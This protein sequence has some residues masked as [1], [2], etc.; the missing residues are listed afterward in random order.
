MFVEATAATKDWRAV[1]EIW[2]K[3]FDRSSDSLGLWLNKAWIFR[4]VGNEEQYRQVVTKVLAL[5]SSVTSVNGQHMA[6]EI[7]A[8]GPVHF[9][10][11]QVNQIDSLIKDL[12]VALPRC[13][14]NQQTRAYRAIGQMQLQ[15]GRFHK[16][17]EALEKSALKQTSLDPYTLFIK[18][19]CLHQLGQTE[20]A[21]AAFGDAEAIMKPLLSEPLSES[22]RFLAA[23]QLYQQL[24]MHREAQAVLAGASPKP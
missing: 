20:D 15:L 12:E 2:R 23:E 18:A 7:A 6:I 14:S 1:A 19:V 3:N 9:S 16:C 24:L 5:A 22:E 11:E 10:A 13:A 8:L 21:R 17:L 4:Y